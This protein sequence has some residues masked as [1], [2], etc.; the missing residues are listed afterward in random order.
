MKFYLYWPEELIRITLECE[1][2]PVLSGGINED[3]IL[4][5]ETLPVLT[6]GINEDHFG[7]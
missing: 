2:L 6:G 3:H 4:A 5:C 1:V 7:V